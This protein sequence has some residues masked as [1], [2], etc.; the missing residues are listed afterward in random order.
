MAI[1][2]TLNRIAS[3][4]ELCDM[5]NQAAFVRASAAEVKS[6]HGY[7]ERQQA[8]GRLAAAIGGMGSLSDIYLLPPDD[9]GISKAEANMRLNKLVEMLD[10]ELREEHGR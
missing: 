10:A 9:A 7:E 8:L 5:Q 3:L 1:G 6:A 2:D 4:L